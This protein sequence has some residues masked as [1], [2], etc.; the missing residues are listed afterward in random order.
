MVVDS[1]RKTERVDSNKPILPNDSYDMNLAG[2]WLKKY[3]KMPLECLYPSYYKLCL[4][5]QQIKVCLH[6]KYCFWS[7]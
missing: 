7:Q 5:K 4:H 3:S 6:I 1:V 2:T